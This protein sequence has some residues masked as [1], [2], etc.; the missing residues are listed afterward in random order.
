MSRTACRNQE[1][2]CSFQLVT[3]E[4]VVSKNVRI[5]EYIINVLDDFKYAPIFYPMSTLYT[6]KPPLLSTYSSNT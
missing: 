3:S 1:D 4:N 5:C 6:G 2:S